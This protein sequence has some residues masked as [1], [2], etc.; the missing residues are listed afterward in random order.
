MVLII[1]PGYNREPFIEQQNHKDICLSR[2]RAIDEAKGEYNTVYD[3]D[4]TC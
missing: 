4:G 1:L 2:N 3:N